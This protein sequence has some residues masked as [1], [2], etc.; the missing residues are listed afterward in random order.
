MDIS[1]LFR[2]EIRELMRSSVH[3]SDYNP[4]KISD[5]GRQLL[6]DSMLQYGIVGGIVVN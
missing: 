5:E 2:S 6:R 3:I 4:R 1:R